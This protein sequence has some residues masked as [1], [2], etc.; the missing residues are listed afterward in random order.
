MAEID[1]SF[2]IMNR[3]LNHQ[4]TCNDYIWHSW[5]SLNWQTKNRYIWYIGS[6][7]FSGSAKFHNQQIFQHINWWNPQKLRIENEMPSRQET[8]RSF[9]F[10]KDVSE[11]CIDGNWLTQNCT[12][13][14]ENR[15]AWN[16]R[17]C[18]KHHFSRVMSLILVSLKGWKSL[19]W[20]A[21]YPAVI[22]DLKRLDYFV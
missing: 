22:P 12:Y 13:N 9:F 20:S 3:T 10:G 17:C 1:K 18:G 11:L 8:G 15:F 7:G 21:A 16:S 14:A 5:N 6:P 19:G 4:Q 2:E